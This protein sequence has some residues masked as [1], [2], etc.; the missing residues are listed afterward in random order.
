MPSPWRMH[1]PKCFWVEAVITACFLTNLMPAR[2]LDFQTPLRM[3]Y[4]FHSNPFTLNVCPKVFSCCATFMFILLIEINLI[5]LLTNMFF[6]A[7]LIHKGIQMFSSS[8][9]NLL[10]VDECS[11]MWK[12]VL[13]SEV[14]SMIPLQR[15]TSNKEE[16]QNMVW[17]EENM[18][19][20]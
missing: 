2:I 8:Y 15:D 17:R 10:R 18:G 7:I 16:E 1:V 9:K 4:R 5:P 13:F 19:L 14:I 6:L 3:F 12:W 20:R 11:I